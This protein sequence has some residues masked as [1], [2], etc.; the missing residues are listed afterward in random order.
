VDLRGV[1]LRLCGEFTEASIDHALI[2]GLA[3]AARGVIRA[4]QDVDFMVAGDAALRTDAVMN[5][6]GYRALHRSENVAN[7]ESGDP[8]QGRVDF[9]FARRPYACAMLERA[10][11]L[12]V[13]GGAA[14]RVL[15]RADLIG[16]KVQAAVNDP[17][18]LRRDFADIASLLERREGVDLDRVREYFRL[19]DLEHELDQLLAELTR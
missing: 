18:R 11:A 13:L 6:L 9:L 5:R 3:L 16:L 2:G 15:D 4:T 14:V 12:P 17:R 1:L 19:F 10:E 8:V 7:Y